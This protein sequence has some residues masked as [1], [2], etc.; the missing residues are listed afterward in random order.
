MDRQGLP[1]IV[2][3]GANGNLGR[4]LLQS[5]SGRAPLRAVVRSERA[6]EQIRALTLE[7]EPEIC[8]VDY[9]DAAAMTGA[10][11]GAEYVVHLVGIIKETAASTYVDAHERTSEVLCQAADSAGALRIVYL[12][13]VGSEPGSSNPCLA[14]KGAAEAILLAAATPALV[15]R[16][17]M[18]LGEGD[19][20]AGALARRARKGWNVLLRGAS[21]EQPIYAGDVIEAVKAGLGSAPAPAALDDAVLDLAGP[22]SLSR[23]DLTRRS[24]SILGRSTRVISLPLFL[25]LLLAGLLERLLA[26]PPVTAAMLR[27]LDHD[28]RLDP[29]PACHV[30]GIELTPLDE[31]LARCLR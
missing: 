14:S 11:A 3:T 28:D 7:P 16:V 8:V 25:G 4:R 21:L 20:A 29:E 2:V 13:I 22:V 31:V 26:N 18:V 23:S 24:A 15:V 27:V 6:A 19:Y 17:P 10:L 5:L 30:L 12:S 9:Q 1:M